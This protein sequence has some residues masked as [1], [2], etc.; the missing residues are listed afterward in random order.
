[1]KNFITAENTVRPEKLSH[2]MRQALRKLLDKEK[3]I[4]P[5]GEENK[6]SLLVIFFVF[7]TCS[8]YTGCSG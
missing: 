4:R 2:L 7:A 3:I 5:K 8:I 6:V 1:M